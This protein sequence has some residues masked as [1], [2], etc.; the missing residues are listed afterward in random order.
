MPSRPL[1]GP[2]IG[3]PEGKAP[4][5]KLTQDQ[6]QYLQHLKLYFRS[7][8]LLPPDIEDDLCAWAARQ[9]DVGGACMA[10]ETCLR[11]GGGFQTHQD[12]AGDLVQTHGGTGPERRSYQ[13]TPEEP[14]IAYC[15][16]QDPGA[17]CSVRL[18]RQRK[19]DPPMGVS[20]L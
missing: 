17:W 6:K 5:V 20:K 15:M 12:S 10:L 19:G 16:E 2:A 4:V 1:L 13:D 7:T 18:A 3:H 8:T 14:L 9:P 11:L